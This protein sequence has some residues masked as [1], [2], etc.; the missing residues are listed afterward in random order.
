MPEYDDARVPFAAVGVLLVIISTIIT[1]YLMGMESAGISRGIADDRDRDFN[2]ALTLAISDI[3]GA[4]NYAGLAAEAEIG[5]TPV[6]NVSETGRFKGSREEVEKERLK[7]LTYRQ[8]SK[9]LEANYNGTFVCGDYC[10]RASLIGDYRSVSV[11]P[12][13][14]TLYRIFD[15]PVAGCE[16]IYPAYYSIEVPVHITV[17]RD[18]TNDSYSGDRVVRSLIASRYP[19]LAAMTEEY[20]RRLN[21]TPMFLD[22]T[23]ASF[24]YTWARGY[25]QYAI[26]MPLNIVDNAQ[27]ELIANGAVLMEQGFEYNSV[28]PLGL[29]ALAYQCYDNTVSPSEVN[30]YDLSNNSRKGLPRNDTVSP[31]RY[32]FNVEE[33]VERAYDNVS[34]GGY[35]QCTLEGAY[36]VR[37]YVD[38]RRDRD[39]CP[40]VNE[41]C[42]VEENAHTEPVPPAGGEWRLLTRTF[43][44]CRD[45]SDGDGYADR[46]TVTYV[47]PEYSVLRYFGAGKYKAAS[48]EM[49]DPLLAGSSNDVSFP[50]SAFDYERDLSFGHKAFRDDNLVNVVRCYEDSFDQYGGTG[51]FDR[52]LADILANRDGWL[53]AVPAAFGDKTREFVC[54]PGNRHPAW[55]E[56]EADY[57]LNDLR[58][59][60]KKDIVVDVDPGSCGGAPA[61]MAQAAYKELNAMYCSRYEGYLDRVSYFSGRDSGG[62][63]AYKSCGSKAIFRIREAFLED[64]RRQLADAAGNCSDRINETIDRRMEGTGQ[65]ASSLTDNVANAKSYL[66]N[67]FYIPF[68]LAMTLNSSAEFACGY[69]WTEEVTMAVDQSP[70]YLDTGLHTDEETGYTVRTLR[71]RN[72]CLFS[73][74]ADIQWTDAVAD[75]L[76]RP[77]LESVD[78]MAKSADRLANDTI[79]AESRRVAGEVSSG[80]KEELKREITVALGEDPSVGG[81]VPPSSIDRA[82][83][84]AWER[85][86]NDPGIIVSDLSNGT[87]V[88]EI[89]GEIIGDSEGA[90]KKKAGEYAEG[91]VDEYTEYFARR[92]EEKIADAE[93]KAITQVTARVKDQILGTVRDFT[94]AAGQE[95]ARKGADAALEKA[96]GKIPSGL[97]LLPPYGWWATINVWYI[98][99]QGVIPVFTAY[100]ADVEPVPDPVFG[101]AAIAYTR[102]H[103]AVAD[104][105]GRFLGNNEPLKFMAKTSTFILVPAGMQ[106]VGDK[107]GGWDEKSA[108]FDEPQEASC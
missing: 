48:A 72:I 108:G 5:R 11:I 60:I 1:V 105:E 27:L 67:R 103:Q 18:G 31:Q 3:S 23:A 63:P 52:A 34:F 8:L 106:G 32:S 78:A 94:R 40:R 53:A 39:C 46:V 4:L 91:Y 55:A 45:N 92:V 83:E 77:L 21:G 73:P 49:G 58:K 75:Q 99:V 69:P 102:R 38:I 16:N 57:E 36:T 29:A 104:E 56:I 15:H 98:E 7:S 9:Y 86:G 47:I 96:M 14:M 54:G 22:L 59:T 12:D 74:G 6:I 28:D 100:D 41:T 79:S 84:R 89:A 13:R 44:V 93:D 43:R 87:L 50:Y 85:R 101:G 2:Q 66:G 42:T 26:G 17:T 20:G 24:A 71:L 107:A 95:I 90:I 25:T 82:V 65:N 81:A 80:I 30:R 68:G 61:A 76:A 37:M 97:P 88:R 35:A 62:R 33:I 51:Y 70:S 19:L 10:V 64:I